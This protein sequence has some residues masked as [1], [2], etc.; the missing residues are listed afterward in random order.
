MKHIIKSV[1]WAVCI[2]AIKSNICNAAVQCGM[3]VYSQPSGYAI[4]PLDVADNCTSTEQIYFCD[5][6][7]MRCDGVTRCTTCTSSGWTF[8]YYTYVDGSVCANIPITQCCKVRPGATTGSWTTVG[9]NRAYQYRQTKDYKCDGTYT[10][11]N[12]YRCAAGYYGNAKGTSVYNLTG[13]NQCP[14]GGTSAAGATV[15]TGCYLPSGTTGSDSTGTYT[16]T[17]NCYYSN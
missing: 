10:T 4:S 13:C 11:T 1:C 7:S 16:Y 2:M 14:S 8:S 15:I 5:Q 3:E 9:Q 12:E 17:S 6:N